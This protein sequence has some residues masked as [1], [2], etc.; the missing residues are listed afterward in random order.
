MRPIT[1]S[2]GMQSRAGSRIGERPD[3]EGAVD[4]LAA[5]GAKDAIVFAKDHTGFCFYPTKIGIMHPKL[6][7]DLTGSMTEALHRRGMKSI[8]YFNIG[9]DGEAARAH[10]NY[11]KYSAPGVMSYFT[12][13]HYAEVCVFGPCFEE[14]ILPLIREIFTVNRVDGAFFDPTGCFN[15]C[16]CETCRTDFRKAF[17]ME[18]PP[19]QDQ[20]ENIE[21]WKKYGEFLSGRIRRLIQRVRDEIHAINPKASV[22]FNHVGGPF[23]QESDFPGVDNPGGISCDPL[24]AYP[25]IS[26]F[27]NHTSAL[28]EGGDVFIERFERC[29]GDRSNLDDLSLQHKCASIFMYG[30]RLCIG[31]RMHPDCSLAPGAVHAMKTIHSLWKDMGGLIPESAVLDPDIICLN[32]KTFL[33]GRFGE[34]AGARG[35]DADY[36]A[37]D[38]VGYLGAYRMLLDCGR[39]F[40]VTPEL[41]LGKK[42]RKD[43][44]LVVPALRWIKDGVAD[45]VRKFVREG[46]TALFIEHVPR[47]DNDEIPD[48][49]G[50]ESVEKDAFQPCIYL[51]DWGK[52]RE[53]D[54]EKPLVEGEIRRI[55]L[56]TAEPVLFGYPQYDLSRMGAGYNS[57]ADE[58]WDVPLL[59]HNS[60]GAGH[61]W[62]LNAP[63]FSDYLAGHPDQ[64]RWTRLLLRHVWK[65]SRVELDS[66]GG[67]VELAAYSCGRGDSLHVLVNHGGTQGAY[68]RNFYG[69]K[70]LSPQPAFRTTLKRRTASAKVRV[71]VNGKQVTGFT[72]ADGIVSLPIVMDSLWKIIRITEL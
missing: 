28:P 24:A 34:K 30:A 35:G 38:L 2:F 26:L 42:L 47:L 22:V 41:F 50:I 71:E 46:G 12:K 58:Q 62:F 45:A 7:I 63:L 4:A 55:G 69:E 3:I 32:S 44:L 52:E 23:G 16:C 43:R 8:A 36:L 39:S 40:M 64:L 13:D 60:Y 53:P 66:E 15:Y 1:W 37:Y 67:S 27:A 6:K 57:S 49:M 19:P 61:V 21:L 10:E 5:A 65:E 70:T 54:M 29:W 68:F 56:S 25:V 17:G 14:Y 11:R 33:G 48:F 59:T 9:M 31:D 51:P 18:L 72:V 20:P